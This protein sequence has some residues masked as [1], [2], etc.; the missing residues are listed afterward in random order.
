[1]KKE[2]KIYEQQKQK[3]K[4]ELGESR[5]K[6]L[7]SRGTQ[8]IIKERGET[9]QFTDRVAVLIKEKEHKIKQLKDHYA[10]NDQEEN[11]IKERDEK[12]K[13]MPKIDPEEFEQNYKRKMAKDL[14]K[15][16]EIERQKE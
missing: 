15:K 9:L 4:E 11:F 16:I 10:L 5:R 6:P 13:S 2:N 1:M 3:E 14:E 8:D 12:Q 7:L